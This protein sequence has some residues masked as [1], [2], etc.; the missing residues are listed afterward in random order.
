[1]EFRGCV[2]KWNLGT[3]ELLRFV[4]NGNSRNGI[5]GRRAQMEFGYEGAIDIC[6]Q[7]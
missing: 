2:P 6:T 1:M 7:W 5:S 3:R 4:R